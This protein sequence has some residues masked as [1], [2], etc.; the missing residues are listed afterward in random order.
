VDVFF[1]PPKAKKGEFKGSLKIFTNDDEFKQII[2]P[3]HGTLK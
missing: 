1:D 2:L 3:V